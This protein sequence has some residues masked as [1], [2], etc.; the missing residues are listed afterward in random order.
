MT[1]NR[2]VTCW[3]AG[4]AFLLMPMAAEARQDAG[5]T[6]FW[7]AAVTSP[8]GVAPAR[9]ALVDDGTRVSGVVV[10]ERGALPVEGTRTPDGVSLRFT[11]TYEGAPML[12]VMKAP[13]AG[14]A[15]EGGVD[16]GGLAEGTWTATRTASSGVNG[17][18]ALSADEGGTP[19][20][21]QLLL[22]EA[23]GQVSGRLLARSRG[24][25]GMVRG[26]VADGV[27]K[28]TV[29]ATADG[30]PI[31][32]DLPGRLTGDTLAGT[33]AVNDLSGRWTAARP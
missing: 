20:R 10:G 30:G 29:D 8:E 33:Y 18:W 13:G 17:A 9:L 5:L 26:S 28:L 2:H 7:D 6:G 27:L 16:F 12:I 21:G 3:L 1:L 15:L 11:I 32:I 23:D 22:V 24:I 25:D 31:V 19:V 4:V 14:D